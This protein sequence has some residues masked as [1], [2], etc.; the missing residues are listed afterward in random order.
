MVTDNESDGVASVGL[1]RNKTS[2]PYASTFDI[3]TR[4]IKNELLLFVLG[5]GIV[6]VGLV[7]LAGAATPLNL[8][9]S[10]FAGLSLV[11][12]VGYYWNAVVQYRDLAANGIRLN[13]RRDQRA[14]VSTPKSRRFWKPFVDS[15]CRIVLGR[16]MQFRR[17]EQ[18][19]FLGVG[20]AIAMTELLL[21]LSQLGADALEVVYADRVGGD[22][23]NS[24]LIVL[25]GP[26]A[27]EISA[28]VV[29]RLESS[30]KPGQNEILDTISK[31][32]HRS[33]RRAGSD[34]LTSDY[35]LVIVAPNPYAPDK[36]MLLVFGTYGFGSWAGIRFL[37]SRQFRESNDLLEGEFVECL[38]ESEIVKG[39]PQ[40]PKMITMRPLPTPQGGVAR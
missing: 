23:L 25:G 9:V 6:L 30:L 7:S 24:N 10:V 5:N 28:D 33:R 17:Y 32:T 18:T 8:I 27:N 21:F 26:V 36:R 29:N 3:L 40:Q 16:L 22:A 37:L 35:G 1:E 11:A 2:M 15:D 20:D 4:K 39:T 13:A 14:L 34:E 31:I 38:V 19:G 12:M